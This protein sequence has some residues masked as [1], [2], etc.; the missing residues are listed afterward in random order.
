MAL[1]SRREKIA[2]NIV[3][4]LETTTADDTR[5]L[6]I[7]KVVREPVVVEDLAVTAMPL[8]FVES[9]D[10]ERDTNAM[11]GSQISTIEFILHLYIKGNTR[12]TDRNVLLEI[13]DTALTTDTTR[14]G[15]ALDTNITDISLISSGESAPYASLAVTVECMYCYTRGDS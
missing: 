15:N 2:A 1:I 11:G 9:A 6:T 3:S 12:D 8:V 7:R 10:E 5:P 13:V 4:T 14:G